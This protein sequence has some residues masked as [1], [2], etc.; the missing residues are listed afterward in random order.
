M[1]YERNYH[2]QLCDVDETNRLTL[3]GMLR[4]LQETAMSHSAS[5]GNG[6]N[7]VDSPDFCHWV[8]YQQKI[9]LLERPHWDTLLHI[10]T[11]SRGTKGFYA[12][13]DFEAFDTNGRKVCQASSVWLQLDPAAGTIR[14]PT[15]ELMSRY[16]MCSDTVFPN[17]LK[18]I[19]PPETWDTE[20]DCRVEYSDIDI[21]GHANNLTYLDHAQQ[22][23]PPGIRTDDFN[24]LDVIFKKA[25]K[26]NDEILCRC[27][28]TDGDI[29][30]SVLR[31]TDRQ[32]LCIFH[33]SHEK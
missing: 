17:A 29:Y 6:P 25:A 28:E 15:A 8:L 1:I 26:E 23:L 14:R 22:A 13:R 21:N 31:K 20:T 3:R 12:F 30:L 11:W 5:A 32:L 2:V 33:L 4:L 27:K 24:I 10:K 16:G 9:L 19:L 7:D 18:K